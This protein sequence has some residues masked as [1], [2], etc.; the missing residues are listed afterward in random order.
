[1]SLADKINKTTDLQSANRPHE[2]NLT[3]GQWFNFIAGLLTSRFTSKKPQLQAET[4]EQ[5]SH[6]DVNF[7]TDTY[8]IVLVTVKDGNNTAHGFM[9]VYLIG[10]KDATEQ[11]IRDLKIE[12]MLTNAESQPFFSLS[13]DKSQPIRDFVL[14]HCPVSA[15]QLFGEQY[16]PVMTQA[17]RPAY[18]EKTATGATILHHEQNL[19]VT[20]NDNISLYPGMQEHLFS[21]ELTWRHSEMLFMSDTQQEEEFEYLA[22]E[23]TAEGGKKTQYI[24]GTTYERMSVVPCSLMFGNPDGLL[25]QRKLKEL[26]EREPALPEDS[27]TPISSTTQS[28]VQGGFIE[29]RGSIPADSASGDWS[30]GNGAG[31]GGAW[32]VEMPEQAGEVCEW[33]HRVYPIFSGNYNATVA[34]FNPAGEQVNLPVEYEVRPDPLTPHVANVASRFVKGFLSL[35]DS[36]DISIRSQEQ[37]ER[38]EQLILNDDADISVVAPPVPP[39]SNEQLSLIDSGHI[40]IEEH[41]TP[42]RT[43]ALEILDSASMTVEE[44]PTPNRREQLSL[45]DSASIDVTTS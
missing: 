32:A 21:L 22:G 29:Y 45:S 40:E 30:V 37:P 25:T 39:V 3:D 38:N 11:S 36:A 44:K 41:P 23:I 7:S 33:R 14:C 24:S 9:S 2:K 8:S 6:L 1:M 19:I 31:F 35:L 16:T 27:E 34:V 28:S 18:V 5:T 4:N 43:E 13:A 20:L 17:Y 10:G 15:L 12:I 42:D 26:Q